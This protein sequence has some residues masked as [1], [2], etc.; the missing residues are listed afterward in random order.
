M[1]VKTNPSGAFLARTGN[2][3]TLY[4]H[5]LTA[6]NRPFF[7]ALIVLIESLYRKSFEDFYQVHVYD[8][9]LTESQRDELASIPRINII[10]M[11]DREKTEAYI[12]S[13]AFKID[14]MHLAQYHIQTNLDKTLLLYLDAGVLVNKSLAGVWKFILR[15]D[16]YIADMSDRIAWNK[17][18][19]NIRLFNTCPDGIA[20]ELDITNEVLAKPLLRPGIFGFR[21]NSPFYRDVIARAY[22]LVRACP[23]LIIGDKFERKPGAERS[24]RIQK[25]IAYCNAEGVA[26]C[27]DDFI[28][29][30]HDQFLFTWLIHSQGY[31]YEQ[32][33]G[34]VMDVTDSQASKRTRDGVFNKTLILG[35]LLERYRETF[36]IHRNGVLR[37]FSPSWKHRKYASDTR[38]IFDRIR[39]RRVALIGPAPHVGEVNKGE[40]VDAYDL[41]FRINRYRA[42]PDQFGSIGRRC[43]GLIHCVSETD[44]TGGA[45]SEV[46]FTAD[47]PMVLFTYPLLADS[48][49]PSTFR[50]HYGNLYNYKR[51]FE[52]YAGQFDFLIPEDSSYLS[53]EAALNSRPNTGFT[54]IL[55][56][57][58]MSPEVLYVSG[59]TF[60]VGG[61]DQTYRQ[62]SEAV[63][64]HK[65]ATHGFHDQQAQLDYFV[66]NVV[67][68]P[69]LRCDQKLLEIVND[70]LAGYKSSDQ[71]VTIVGNGP[72]LSAINLR[73]LRSSVTASFNRAYIIYEEQ[74]YYPTYYF[75]IDKAV[76]LN[77]LNDIR[78]LL[79][80]PIKKVVLLDCDETRD[81]A[82][83]PKVELVLRTK[84]SALC[85][86]DVATFSVWYLAGVGYRRFDVLGCDCSYIEDIETLGVN[87]ETNDDDPARRIVLKPRKGSV[88]PN[89]FIPNY[90]CEGTEYS[91]PRE[92]NHLKAWMA[93]AELAKTKRLRVVFRTPSKASRLFEFK[94]YAV[95]SRAH[96]I[97]AMQAEVGPPLEYYRHQ[98]A[99]VDETR[100]VATLLKSQRGQSRVML[101]VGAHFGM[102]AGFFDDLGWTVHCFEPDPGNRAKLESRHGANPRITIDPRALGDKPM[103]GV[104]FFTSP[105][106]TGISGLLA[107]RDTH[108][109]SGKVDV[110]TVANVVEA[111]GIKQIDFLKIDVEG[112]DLNVLYY[113]K[114]G[115]AS[116]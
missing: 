46:L 24:G 16:S 72:S 96:E 32:S 14:M 7:D 56:L 39:G 75:C 44:V 65:M 83:H 103:K 25:V 33:T 38:A 110:T 41:V 114:D 58:S 55:R 8:I 116:R 79:D 111:R 78:R 37:D 20:D 97:A 3:N 67:H 31:G 81:L 4:K 5:V 84:E 80:S 42:N 63:V 92:A 54:G 48:N 85:F 62:E 94:P 34:M 57:L 73:T 36:L 52:K 76:L 50:E 23:D 98:H 88:D 30:R 51:I 21:L 61:Y 6:C 82:K 91:V 26:R 101:D 43:D 10:D 45:I 29:Y 13:Y 102:T 59:F 68:E 95:K 106:S 112:F 77:C 70:R 99:T 109:E 115:C 74:N 15:N 1:T 69:T 9:G 113:G 71:C 90:F 53:L 100:V 66:T 28:G 60:F 108:E 18:G 19:D 64:M 49:V 2:P 12:K 27:T 17:S 11:P 104:A 47:R 107:F 40:I 22:D 87:V 105:E 93:V 89:H 86:G 35:E